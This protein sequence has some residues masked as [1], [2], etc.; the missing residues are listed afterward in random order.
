MW[1]HYFGEGTVVHGVDIESSCLA[2]ATNGIRI[3]IGDQASPDFWESFKRQV[4]E[5]DIVVDD[6]GHMAHQQVPALEALL[7]IVS[8]GGVYLCEDIGGLHNRFHAYIAGLSR[9]L[10]Y[11]VRSGERPSGFQQIVH[12][13]HLYP[14]MAVIEKRREPM[15]RMEAPRHGTVWEPFLY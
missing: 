14:F 12:S 6:G 15:A 1:R 4:P 2:Y 7:P 13:V 5:V 3:H 10:H 11:P 8:A 9:N